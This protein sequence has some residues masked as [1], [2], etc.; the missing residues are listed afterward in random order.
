MLE[1]DAAVFADRISAFRLR[2]GGSPSPHPFTDLDP[3]VLVAAW[4]TAFGARAPLELPAAVGTDESLGARFGHV[5][6]PLVT[7]GG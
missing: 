5:E 4:L 1:G 2:L 3:A 6:I 7:S